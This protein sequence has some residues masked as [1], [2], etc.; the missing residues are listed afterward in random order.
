MCERAGVGHGW[1]YL[2]RRYRGLVGD[3]FGM[4]VGTGRGF[5]GSTIGTQAAAQAKDI[6]TP[7]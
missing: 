7:L 2:R 4:R 1:T 5:Q 6:L 3:T